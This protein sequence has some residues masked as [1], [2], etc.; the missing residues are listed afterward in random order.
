MSAKVTLFKVSKIVPKVPREYSDLLPQYPSEEITF[1]LSGVS[2]AVANAFRR[3]PEEIPARYLLCVGKDITTNDEYIINDFIAMRIRS[4]PLQQSVPVGTSWE[5]S[6]VN[7]TTELIEIMT[8]DITINGKVK[9][10][11]N[12]V[13]CTLNPGRQ[14]YIKGV[15]SE[16]MSYIDGNGTIPLASLCSSTVVDVES[17][18]NT[19]ED[20]VGTPSRQANRLEW[21][22]SMITPGHVDADK[23]MISVCDNI[24]ARA[25]SIKNLEP[26]STKDLHELVIIGETHTLGALLIRECELIKD[27]KYYSYRPDPTSFGI[28]FEI[29][30]DSDPK[31]I[32]DSIVESIVH[33]FET[34]RSQF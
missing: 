22:I 21:N 4:I 17:L 6:A 15:V 25:K 19:F 9:P 5:L 12:C 14:I 11:N 2:N 27:I 3:C 34:L 18:P 16:A 24:I 23:L 8:H 29:R 28:R 10:F 26:V 30:C 20:H 32:I 13:L 31:V 7:N 1:R 33:K